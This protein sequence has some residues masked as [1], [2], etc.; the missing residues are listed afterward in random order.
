M[1]GAVWLDPDRTSP[2]EFHQYWLNVDDR[3]VERFLLQLTLLSL[4]EVAA[5]MAEHTPAPEKRVAQRALA[6]AVTTLIHGSEA[7]EASKT[8]SEVLFGGKIP[9]PS[10][11]AALRGI[12][13]ETE[14]VLAD[15]HATEPVVDLLVGSGLCS[16]R[17][18]AR[19]SLTDGAVRWNG[20]R[21]ES[22]ASI[23]MGI[24]SLGLLQRGKRNK[25]LI[26]FC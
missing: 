10:D 17:R 20:V 2:Y 13:P 18:E 15:V 23:E 7:V 25:H 4:D 14:V 19:Q 22:E 9:S 21:L 8:A 3:D 1:S 5:V 16:S 11:L 24:G 12:V 6:D 26:V